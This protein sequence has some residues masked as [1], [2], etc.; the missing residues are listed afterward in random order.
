[1]FELALP[2]WYSRRRDTPNEAA[3]IGNVNEAL[4]VAIRGHGGRSI[5]SCRC[6]PLDY[7]ARGRNRTN[8]TVPAS[9]NH[10]TTWTQNRTAGGHGPNIDPP[11]S[12][13]R[14]IKG[15]EVAVFR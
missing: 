5:L 10:R 8:Y 13:T 11:L 1:M 3:F 6:E 4:F 2:H 12:I 15:I 7:G 14:A 9:D